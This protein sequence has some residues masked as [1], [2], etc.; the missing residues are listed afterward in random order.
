MVLA[1]SRERFDN[2]IGTISIMILDGIVWEQ[3]ADV[4]VRDRPQQGIR[5]RMQQ[6][7]GVAVPNRVDFGVD[8]PPTNSQGTAV[9]K[10]V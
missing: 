2:K 4:G 10:S 5:N 8:T 6:D 7:I 3:S 9:S 1:D